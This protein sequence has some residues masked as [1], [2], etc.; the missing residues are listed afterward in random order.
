M[1]TSDPLFPK[2]WL[3][4]IGQRM[5]SNSRLLWSLHHENPRTI[6]DYTS[7]A[8]Q[9]CDLD[10]KR[11]LLDTFSD[12]GVLDDV[13]THYIRRCRQHAPEYIVG[14]GEAIVQY[15]Q[16][17]TVL[18]LPAT[19]MVG[20]IFGAGFPASLS[21]LI[22]DGDLDSAYDEWL[23]IELKRLRTAIDNWLQKNPA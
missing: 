17:G 5:D 11:D 14:L 23:R 10:A 9:A 12:Q 20:N 21:R 19:P 4:D 2:N 22:E 8:W 6:L 13:L 1:P 7:D 16:A 3:G 15:A 18:R